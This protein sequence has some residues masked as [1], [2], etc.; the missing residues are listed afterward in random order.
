MADIFQP[1]R[2]MTRRN[3]WLGT[4][5]VILLMALAST[6]FRPAAIAAFVLALVLVIQ[7]MRNVGLPV[8]TLII[9]LLSY[10]GFVRLEM[11]MCAGIPECGLTTALAYTFLTPLLYIALGIL[12]SA[13][14]KKK[15]KK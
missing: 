3:Y 9:Y 6:A 10:I 14:F 13:F 7:R 1:L 5:A 8:W 15:P 4:I 2:E 11:Q 12:P